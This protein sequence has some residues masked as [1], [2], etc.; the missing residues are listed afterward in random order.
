[1]KHYNWDLI[2]GVAQASMHSTES[3]TGIVSEIKHFSHTV[4]GLRADVSAGH[5]IRT[6]RS[7]LDFNQLKDHNSIDKNQFFDI[8]TQCVPAFNRAFWTQ[9]GPWGISTQFVLYVFAVRGLDPGIYVLIRD[10]KD[11]KRLKSMLK[12][13]SNVFIRVDDAPDGLGSFAFSQFR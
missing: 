7:A 2:A 1:L 8:L 11:R 9:L 3:S 6:R 5:L 4:N 12:S 13:E 10:P